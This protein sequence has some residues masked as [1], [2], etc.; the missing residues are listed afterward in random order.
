MWLHAIWCCWELIVQICDVCPVC[1]GFTDVGDVPFGG[2]SYAFEAICLVTL[3]LL[4]HLNPIPH[5]SFYLL[6]LIPPSTS[7]RSEFRAHIP[8]GAQFSTQDFCFKFIFVT[9]LICIPPRQVFPGRVS[10][11]ALICD[12]YYRFCLI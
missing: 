7:E 5:N 12:Y 11:S 1:A 9:F 10:L 6:Y 4:P 2:F 3:S 8:P